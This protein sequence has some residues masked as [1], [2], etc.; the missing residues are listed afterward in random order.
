MGDASS[1]SL[2]ETGGMLEVTGRGSNY[3]QD[4][5]IRFAYQSISG[6]FRVETDIVSFSAPVTGQFSKGGL[7]IR[8]GTDYRDRRV[9]VNYVPNSG[10]LQFA[11]RSNSGENFSSR[12]ADDVTISLPVRV[13]IERTG[14]TFT[15]QYS[16]NGG[17]TWITPTGQSNGVVSIGMN[18]DLLAGIGISSYSTGQ[19]F[20]GRFDNLSLCQIVSAGV[21]YAADVD[22]NISIPAERPHFAFAGSGKTWQVVTFTGNYQGYAMQSLPNTG[23]N[24]GDTKNGAEMRYEVDFPATL[25]YPRTYYFFA[26]AYADSS[27]GATNNDSFHVALNGGTPVTYGGTGAT[28]FGSSWTWVSTF[29]SNPIGLTIPSA[30]VHTLNIFMREDGAA[31][32]HFYLSPVS[33][34]TMPVLSSSSSCYTTSNE[35]WVA[36]YTRTVTVADQTSVT[37]ALDSNDGHRM[38]TRPLGS[39]NWSLVGGNWG[40]GNKTTNITQV[41]QP[42]STQV[43][44]EYLALTGTDGNRITLTYILEGNVFHSDATAGGNYVLYYGASLLLGGEVNLPTGSHATLTWWEKYDVGNLDSI[45]VEINTVSG[46][47]AP[48]GGPSNGTRV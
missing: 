23:T 2:A 45:I 28:G 5:N 35:F 1:G 11:Y 29:S 3:W 6:D 47:D 4:D 7:T 25:T 37:F 13:A 36:R 43:M 15:V 38:Y 19:N 33:N 39:S 34:P 20:T 27:G 16:T 21:P 9:M 10:S 31:L 44:I 18:D 24:A 14:T 26:R 42:G 8:E 30:G 48:P 22:G 40:T 17:T 12:M 46:Y 41:F 32:D